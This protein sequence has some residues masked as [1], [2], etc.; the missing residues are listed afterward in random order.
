MV[1]D[2]L[3][4]LPINQESR[5]SWRRIERAVRARPATLSRR[6]PAPAAR[7]RSWCRRQHR[8]PGDVLEASGSRSRGRTRLLA[9]RHTELERGRGVR[10]K[11]RSSTGTGRVT[12]QRTRLDRTRDETRQDREEK[13][14][15]IEE[16]R[17]VRGSGI[18][19]H[20][21]ESLR[22]EE[23]PLPQRVPLPLS[24]RLSK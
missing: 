8:Y 7:R 19:C 16:T 14:T 13:R 1:E 5:M 15:S 10:Q 22:E 9:T 24:G 3:V 2:R 6:I 17:P 23:A 4:R 11:L 18:W 12:K 20:L 21:G